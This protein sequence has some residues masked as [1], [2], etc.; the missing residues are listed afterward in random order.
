MADRCQERG[1]RFSTAVVHFKMG[2]K[3]FTIHHQL[4]VHVFQEAQ[5]EV[6]LTGVVELIMSLP[7]KEM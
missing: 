2:K 7:A 4:A 5:V 6:Q 1:E 3:Y